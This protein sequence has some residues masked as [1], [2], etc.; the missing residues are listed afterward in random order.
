M[1]TK[2]ETV[3]VSVVSTQERGHQTELD[4]S[5][6]PTR[7]V[8]ERIACAPR[9]CREPSGTGHRPARLAGPTPGGYPSVN[10]SNTSLA[11]LHGER[12]R[13]EPR[14]RSGLTTE[15]AAL[16]RLRTPSQIRRSRSGHCAT[17]PCAGPYLVARSKVKSLSPALISAVSGV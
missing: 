10:R 15:S 8:R 5:P 13:H 12:P 1:M 16:A 6:P 14:V 4:T 9:R 3:S 11:W 2:G 7:A 17:D